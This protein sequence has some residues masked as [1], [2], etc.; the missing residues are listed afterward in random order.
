MD[1]SPGPQP[2]MGIPMR[3]WHDLREGTQLTLLILLVLVFD[4]VAGVILL[5]K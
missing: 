3:R 4:V 1:D 5:A 2:E